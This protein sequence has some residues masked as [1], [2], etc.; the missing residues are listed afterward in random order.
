[1]IP[2]LDMRARHAPKRQEFLDAIGMVIDSGDFSGGAAV[3][4]FESDFAAYCGTAHAIAVGNGTEALWLALLAMGIGP[5]DE[6]ITV[7]M[8]FIA[9]VE[10][11][12]MAGATPVFVD[13]DERT[14]TMDPAALE[15]ALSARTVVATSS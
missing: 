6:V 2:F 5:G 14:F 11:I 8:T 13:I 12:L 3:A 1:M 9:T 4:D 10:A 7:P 15:R